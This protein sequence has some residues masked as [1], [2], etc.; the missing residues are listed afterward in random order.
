MD[1]RE[2]E[3]GFEKRGRESGFEREKTGVSELWF[4]L[5][6]ASCQLSTIKDSFLPESVPKNIS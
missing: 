4:E 2:R 5:G 1:L 6:L 3:S